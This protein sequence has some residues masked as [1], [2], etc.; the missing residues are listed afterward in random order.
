MST[1]INPIG[2]KVL[3]QVVEAEDKTQGGLF[4]PDTAKEKSK[5]G[6][7][8]AVGQGRLL[9][10]GTLVPLTVKVGHKVVFSKYGI[11]ELTFEG[12]EYLLLPE[13][14]ILAVIV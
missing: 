11:T 7:V 8:I 9:E 6:M 1:S 13:A 3:L 2:D 12:K 14:S 10:N 5:T 4:L